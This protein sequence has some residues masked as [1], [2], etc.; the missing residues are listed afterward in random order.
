[1]KGSALVQGL[2]RLQRL[3]QALQFALVGASAAA[4][5]LLVV[6]LLVHGTGMAPLV[7][8]GLAFVVAFGVS[9]NG[10]ALLTFARTQVRGWAVVARYFPVASLSFAV[11]EVLYAAGT[12]RFPAGALFAL[13]DDKAVAAFDLRDIVRA[14]GLS[15]RCM[16]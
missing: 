7:A 3:P 14:L 8:N 6:G 12:P 13:H 11:N 15:E 16:R 9:Y 2:Q 10:H 4:T 5:H 1:M